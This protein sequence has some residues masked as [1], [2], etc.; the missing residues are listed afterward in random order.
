MVDIKTH[1]QHYVPCVSYS[2]Q[3][4]IDTGITVEVE[5]ANMH[6]ILICGDQLTAARA[7]SAQKAKLNAHT[8]SKRLEGLVS[9]LEDW[10][11]KAN[12]SGVSI[13]RSTVCNYIICSS[14]SINNKHFIL[15]IHDYKFI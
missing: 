4:E 13:M 5:R 7:R 1:V 8:P 15:N 14:R 10:H 3:Q 2:V 11:T 9:V 6:R 12:L